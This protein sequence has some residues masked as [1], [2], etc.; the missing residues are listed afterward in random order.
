MCATDEISSNVPPDRATISIARAP[1]AGPVD[2][3]ATVPAG[4]GMI[5]QSSRVTTTASVKKETVLQ[6]NASVAE[7]LISDVV[8][9][10]RPLTKAP[11][12]HINGDRLF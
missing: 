10:I 9:I 8:L 3:I 4:R 1:F 5:S 11:S 7:D 12:L 6:F 2:K